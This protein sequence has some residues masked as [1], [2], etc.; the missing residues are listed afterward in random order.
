MYRVIGMM[1]GTSMD[2]VDLAYCEFEEQKGK[3]SFEIKYAETI[4][5]P[6]V[7]K[8]RLS[9]LDEQ[10]IFLYPK[11]DAFY[12]K[13]I[14]QL[15]ND[16]IEKNNLKVDLISSHGHTIFHQPQNGFTAQIGSGAAIYAETNIPVVCD[17]RSVDVALGGQGAPLVPL[18]D[19]MLFKEYDACLNLGGF[20]NISFSKNEA[21]NAFDICP[22]NIVLN[23]ITE[24]MNLPFDDE[25]KIASSGI[26]NANLLE[27]LNAI[28]F[29]KIEGSKSLGKEWVNENVW[30]VMKKYDSLNNEDLM[31]TFTEHIATQISNKINASKTSNILATGG[32]V[33]NKYLLSRIE[34]KSS[35][36]IATPSANIINYKE[37]LIFAFLGLLNMLNRNNII[38]S[39]TGAKQNSIG[40]AFYGSK[41]Q[42][43]NL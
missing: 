36:K 19:T 23:H 14:G 24:W 9:K 28:G 38:S 16:F 13:Y 20:A 12:G 31:A 30:P 41:V 35:S 8:T 37:A 2:G 21:I 26:V 17:F 3:W 7:W 11:T 4:P 29:Y 27:E 32:G 34:I 43:Q 18:G 6:E 10:P 42:P 5:Y 25:G 39:V 33:F 22:C 15:I 40:G 1:S